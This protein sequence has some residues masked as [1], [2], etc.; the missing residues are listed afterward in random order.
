MLSWIHSTFAR[1]RNLLVEPKWNSPLNEYPEAT[2]S[3]LLDIGIDKTGSTA[4]QTPETTKSVMLHIGTD[5]TGSTALQTFFYDNVGIMSSYGFTYLKAGRGNSQNHR[6]I[7]TRTIEG[8]FTDWQMLSD[9]LKGGNQPCGIVSFEG[10]YHLNE[11]QLCQV[12]D[13]LSDL[14]VKVIVYLRRQSDMVRSGVAQRIKGGCIHLPLAQYSADKLAAIGQDYQPMLARFVA[15]FGRA[16]VLVRRYEH[17]HWPEGSIF[18][19]FL[20]VLDLELDGQQLQQQFR[21][22]QRDP[23]PTLDVESIQLLDTLDLLGIHEDK[24]RSV[25][26]LLLGLVSVDRSTFVSDQLAERVDA[27][28]DT[29][30]RFIAREWFG[31]DVLFTAPSR[32]KYRKP[33]EAEVSRYFTFIRHWLA[34]SQWTG[35]RQS[36]QI[37]EEEGMLRLEPSWVP[38]EGLLKLNRP[39]AA[40][41]FSVKATRLTDLTVQVEGRWV[42]KPGRLKVTAHGELLYEGDAPVCTLVVPGW[43]HSRFLQMVELQFFIEQLE[44][45]EQPIYLLDTISYASHKILSE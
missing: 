45:C 28:F 31:E 9:E 32:F 6:A 37:L 13:R 3:V 25:V 15:V 39:Q 43:L 8:D 27:I 41:F 21:L 42:G 4:L 7:H 16:N 10:F 26:R 44:H 5:K 14:Q 11:E 20:H 36:V 22:P 35:T 30:N 34:L 24:R 1:I 18:L 38:M 40:I 29:S 23:N 17:E 2:K 12:R 33:S 19:D